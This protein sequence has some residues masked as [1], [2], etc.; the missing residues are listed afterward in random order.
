[1]FTNNAENAKFVWIVSKANCNKILDSVIS[2]VSDNLD[3]QQPQENLMLEM[4][5]GPSENTRKNAELKKTAPLTGR[6]KGRTLETVENQRLGRLLPLLVYR[7]HV[8]AKRSCTFASHRVCILY[9]LLHALCQC[10]CLPAMFFCCEIFS[11]ST[12]LV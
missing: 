9:K 6:R 12:E 10:C 11:E 5:M 8:S 4:R 2:P 3:I 1:M 7:S